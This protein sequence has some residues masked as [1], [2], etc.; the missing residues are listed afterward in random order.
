VWITIIVQRHDEVGWQLP[1]DSPLVD[2]A[3]DERWR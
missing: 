2:A 1:G 3:D